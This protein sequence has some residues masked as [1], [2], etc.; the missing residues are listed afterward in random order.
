MDDFGGIFLDFLDG[1]WQNSIFTT[2]WSR[3][4]REHAPAGAARP[5][6]RNW[7]MATWHGVEQRESY[8]SEAILV[9][10]FEGSTCRKN[11]SYSVQVPTPPARQAARAAALAA[12]SSPGPRRGAHR[13]SCSSAH[14][15]DQPQFGAGQQ[16][17]HDA[18]PGARR[19]PRCGAWSECASITACN[20][21]CVCI[22]VRAT[23]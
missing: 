5:S 13:R 22:T 16:R 18:R 9:R 6:A 10:S 23:R 12:N 19:E 17:E 1:M 3:A 15:T 11:T 8:S 2:A 4:G 7:P 14:H 20:T 21:L